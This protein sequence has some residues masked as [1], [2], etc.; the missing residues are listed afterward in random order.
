MYQAH[1]G[2]DDAPF[3]TR[4]DRRF[5]YES[6]THEEALA[7]LHFLVDERRRL[8]LLLGSHGSGKSTVLEFFSDEIRRR[9]RPG[10]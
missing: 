9:G 8:G 3:R 10:A 5:F 7:R 6:P 1:W 4:L 2:L